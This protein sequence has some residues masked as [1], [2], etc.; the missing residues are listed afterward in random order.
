MPDVARLQDDVVSY[1]TELGYYAHA[2]RKSGRAVPDRANH[3]TIFS[4]F[5]TLWV[6]RFWGGFFEVSCCCVLCF[7][8]WRFFDDVKRH[9]RIRACERIKTV[10]NCVCG[11]KLKIWHMKRIY[12]YLRVCMYV[13][14][15]I[16][17]CLFICLC[18][19]IYID[20]FICIHMCK[21]KNIH[22]MYEHAHS[23]THAHTYTRIPNN[24]THL[25]ASQR[26]TIHQCHAWSCLCD[27]GRDVPSARAPD[28]G[29]WNQNA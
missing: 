28:C 25:I 17:V 1:A 14:M 21:H 10:W 20:I 19:C 26:E 27:I 3:F 12:V 15:Y 11:L 2:I 13:R 5:T 23:H 4:L 7:Y 22:T 29:K 18:A 24:N 8:D 6:S 16:F 9:V